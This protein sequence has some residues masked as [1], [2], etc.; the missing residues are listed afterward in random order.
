MRIVF[1]DFDGVLNSEAYM[2]RIWKERKAG[3][4]VTFMHRHTDEIC[5]EMA[6]RVLSICEQADASVVISSSWRLLHTMEEIK[7]MLTEVGAGA[8]AA[9]IIGRTPSPKRLRSMRGDEIDQWLKEFGDPVTAF[10]I[11]DDDSDMLNSQKPMFVQTHWQTGIM[12]HH[13]E[14]AVGILAA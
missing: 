6:Q 1:L 2:H 14:Q 11:L 9:R 10:V 13:V 7:A 5:P 4:A 12:D 3:K 8:L